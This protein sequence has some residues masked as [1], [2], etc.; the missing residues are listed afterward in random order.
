M[1]LWC[2]VW[3]IFQ[4]QWTIQIVGTALGAFLALV[5]AFFIDK[6]QRGDRYSLQLLATKDELDLNE[7]SIVQIINGL[8]VGFTL[9]HLSDQNSSVLA[10]NHDLYQ[11]G[12]RNLIVWLNVYIKTVRIA[13][14]TIDFCFK[15]WSEGLWEADANL[16]KINCKTLEEKTTA[17]QV[18]AKQLRKYI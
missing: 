3:E 11:F 17:V 5:I 1:N 9:D 15:H 4:N 10:T 2:T 8:I 18:S 16:K 7:A 14:D 12:K 13:N 6:K